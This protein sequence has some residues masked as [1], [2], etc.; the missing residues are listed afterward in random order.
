MDYLDVPYTL[1]YLKKVDLLLFLFYFPKQK[2]ALM[3]EDL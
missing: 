1:S 2:K 3:N